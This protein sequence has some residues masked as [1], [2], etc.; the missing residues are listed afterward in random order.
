MRRYEN[1]SEFGSAQLTTP[2]KSDMVAKLAMFL[3]KM[4]QL[5]ISPLLGS[6]CRFVPTCSEYASEAIVS[7]GVLKGSLLA[8]KR[9]LRCHPFNPGGFDPVP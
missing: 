5:L 1:N 6:A 9:I 4:Y 8:I 3:I 2:A 7:H